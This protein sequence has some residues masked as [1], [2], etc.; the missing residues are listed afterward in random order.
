MKKIYTFLAIL[1]VPTIL[2]TYSFSGG[3]PGG[4]SGSPIDNANCTQCHAGATN[5]I[6]GWIASDIPDEGFTA[7]ETYLITLNATDEDAA[8]FGFE[9]TA[10]SG[11][12]KI[13]TFTITDADRTQLKATSNSVTHTFTGTDP[14]GHDITW[15]FEWTAPDPSP[16]EVSFYAAI[17]A[18]NGNGQ[19]SG[20]KVYLT[21]RAH[22]QFFVGIADNML[23]EQVNVYPNPATS[24][25][26]VNMPDN[27]ELRLINIT[28]QEMMYQKNTSGSER[29]DLSNLAA[30][31]YFVQ[32][33]Q[34]SEM[35]TIK[36]LKN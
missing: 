33:I 23:K 36:L 13:G 25:V 20:D 1:S 16:D 22:N 30:G 8:R 31:V 27:A 9:L 35:A 2:L 4:K 18:A 24:F 14:I 19:N 3:S 26:N 15:S 12:S 7:G 11:D 17:N 6:D 34:N 5:P 21:S 29:I 32:V 10:E 28:G